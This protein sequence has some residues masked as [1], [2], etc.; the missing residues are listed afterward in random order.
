MPSIATHREQNKI[1]SKQNNELLTHLSAL[2]ES[3]A[4]NIEK[5]TDDCIANF[6]RFQWEKCPEADKDKFDKLF[7]KLNKGKGKGPDL[8]SFFSMIKLNSR[9]HVAAWLYSSETLVSSL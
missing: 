8:V 2:I 5:I 9:C 4:F 7:D 6:N 1:L 3:S